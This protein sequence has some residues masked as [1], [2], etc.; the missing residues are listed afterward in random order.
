MNI[1]IIV[2]LWGCTDAEPPPSD[3]DHYLASVELASTDPGAAAQSCAQIEEAALAGEC[4]SF[5]AVALAMLALVVARARSGAICSSR[6]AAGVDV[7]LRGIL[8][9]QPHAPA[10]TPR[11]LSAAYG[12]SG[13]L[14]RPPGVWGFPHVT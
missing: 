6:G 12:Q 3:R 2:L 5:A 9:I 7:C 1:G 10:P 11:S 4:Q 13:C 14:P 8:A